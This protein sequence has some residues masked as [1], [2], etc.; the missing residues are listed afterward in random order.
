M[1]I[2]ANCTSHSGCTSALAPASSSTVGVEP[3]TGI[4]VAIAGRLTPLIRPIRSSAEAIVA[5]VL[6]AEIIA[7]RDRREPPRR[8]GRASSPS[9]GGRPGGVLVHADDLAG[10]DQ[11]EVAVD[12][13]ETGRADED[14]GDARRSTAWCAPARI[15]P[16][17]LSP[18][19][20]STAIGS[21]G[22]AGIGRSG[23]DVDDVAV[24]VP[25]ARRAH[26][27]RQLGLAAARAQAARRGV[28]LPGGSRWLRVFIF[29]FFF[30]GTA[31]WSPTG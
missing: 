23:S 16:G 17:A 2:W 25:P 14:D 10:R 24:L 12:A 6:P 15:S 18:P 9:C 13:V 1:P 27:V 31:T 20:A 19:I 22:S 30:L 7:P 3:G 21:I 11:R 8:H 26:R 29:D 28:E 4:G 5:P